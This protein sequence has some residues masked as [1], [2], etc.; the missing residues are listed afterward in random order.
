MLLSVFMKG[1]P[2]LKQNSPFLLNLL[3]FRADV[4][5]FALSVSALMFSLFLPQ[6]NASKS[7]LYTAFELNKKIPFNTTNLLEKC[8][9][10]LMGMGDLI[11]IL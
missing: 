1:K 6:L 9:L 5:F 7:Y 11:S 2:L 8:F 4:S 10:C 3:I